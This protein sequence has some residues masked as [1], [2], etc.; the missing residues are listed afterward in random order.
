[1]ERFFL[2]LKMK[3]VWQRDC[4]NHGEAMSDIADY[5]VGFYN[6]VRLHCA[7]RSAHCAIGHLML[8]SRHQPSDVGRGWQAAGRAPDAPPRSVPQQLGGDGLSVLLSGG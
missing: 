7:V 3:R 6:S 8:W 1:M 5:I 4:A 2:N